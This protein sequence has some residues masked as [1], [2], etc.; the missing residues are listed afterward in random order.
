M[1][2]DT[3]AIV[4]I[5]AGEPDAHRYRTALKQHLDLVMSAFTVFECRTVLHRRLQRPAQGEFDDFLRLGGVEIVPFDA[6]HA[7][8]AFAAYR[9]YGKGSGHEAQL[10]LGGCAAYALAVSLDLP[11]L[12]KGEDFRHT[13]VRPALP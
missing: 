5:V 13:D 2:V 10:N 6:D 3:S 9:K 8:L 7:T 11:L 4:A 1:V 12:F